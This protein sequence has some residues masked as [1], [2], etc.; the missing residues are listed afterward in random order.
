MLHLEEGENI[1]AALINTAIQLVI[2][3]IIVG[4]V[5]AV[6]KFS[7]TLRVSGDANQWV[8]VMRNGKMVNMGIGLNTYRGYFDQVARFSSRVNQ[9][10]FSSNVVTKEMQEVDIEGVVV[11]SIFR[12]DDGPNLAYKTFGEALSQKVPT[13]ANDNLVS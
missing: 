12:D 9:V 6:Y 11:W 2:M 13:A 5:Q 7:Q 10:S 1:S 4:G 8:L 3:A